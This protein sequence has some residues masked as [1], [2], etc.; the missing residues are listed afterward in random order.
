MLWCRNDSFIPGWSLYLFPSCPVSG[1]GFVVTEKICR[2]REDSSSVI[3]GQFCH[4]KSP[5]WYPCAQIESY[6]PT[7]A[8]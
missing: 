3:G 4:T 8:L 5:S 7:F 1:G 2:F 6:K